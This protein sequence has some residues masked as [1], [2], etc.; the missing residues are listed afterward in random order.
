M[1]AKAAGT[2][3]PPRRGR[4]MRPRLTQVGA[5]QSTLACRRRA[6]L[7][8]FE[9]VEPEPRREREV[10]PPSLGDSARDGTEPHTG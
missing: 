6:T 10:R 7:Q 5:F 4:R 8:R 9:P 2:D 1:Y 3:G